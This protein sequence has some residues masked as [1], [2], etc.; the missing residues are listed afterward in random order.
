MSRKHKLGCFSILADSK[1]VKNVIL[2]L[3]LACV[4]R[5]D[6]EQAY[7]SPD[8]QYCQKDTKDYHKDT[9]ILVISAP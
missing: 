6:A 5:V 8:V 9:R 3:L 2:L 7:T 4:G 1:Y